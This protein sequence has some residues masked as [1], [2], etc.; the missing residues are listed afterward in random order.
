MENI[1]EELESM[2]I[3]VN[4]NEFNF[5]GLSEVDKEIWLQNCSNY[6]TPPRLNFYNPIPT[7]IN[8]NYSICQLG[9]QRYIPSA[10]NP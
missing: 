3:G 6:C 7:V 8:L 5:D 9:F 4:D 2:E 10:S 1:T